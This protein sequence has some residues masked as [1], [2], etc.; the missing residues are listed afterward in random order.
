[1]CIYVYACIH[2]HEANYVYICTHTYIAIYVHI[3]VRVCTLNMYIHVH[4][5]AYLHMTSLWGLHSEES[6]TRT[7]GAST[8]SDV[9]ETVFV[10]EIPRERFCVRHRVWEKD[11]HTR[12]YKYAYIYRVHVNVHYHFQRFLV[13]HHPVA[14]RILHTQKHTQTHISLDSTCSACDVRAACLCVFVCQHLF[15]FVLCVRSCVLCACI[16][17]NSQM[18]LWHFKAFVAMPKG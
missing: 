13:I 1:M 2:I 17:K 14:V 3:C 4:T 6:K 8:G 18:F 11:T 7:L 10:Q 16:T 9:C 12:V 5:P 15:V